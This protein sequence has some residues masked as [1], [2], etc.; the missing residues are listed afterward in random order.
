[1]TATEWRCDGDGDDDKA[2]AMAMAVIGQHA[3]EN[4]RIDG[5]QDNTAHVMECPA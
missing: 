5:R 4:I 2:K 3:R 1:M